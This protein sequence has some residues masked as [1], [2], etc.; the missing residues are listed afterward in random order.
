M[1]DLIQKDTILIVGADKAADSDCLLTAL[2]LVMAQPGR[3]FESCESLYAQRLL[4]D[5]VGAVV[6]EWATQKRIGFE[7]LTE[8]SQLRPARLCGVIAV[9]S[10]PRSGQVVARCLE[11]GVECLAVDTATLVTAN[12][13]VDNFEAW[14]GWNLESLKSAP[15]GRGFLANRAVPRDDKNV[16]VIPVTAHADRPRKMG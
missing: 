6:T 10:D 11:A 5:G 9:S 4:V 12:V 15:I 13:S 7:Q 8:P 3:W 14:C 16:A 1:N 2:T